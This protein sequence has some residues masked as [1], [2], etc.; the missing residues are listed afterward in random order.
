MAESEFQGFPP[1]TVR[2][3]VDLAA[4][5]D[6]DWFAANK[7]RYEED[8]VRPARAFITSVGSRLREFAPHVV[9]DPRVNGSLFR[10]SRDT[11]FSHD[12][13]PFKT[14]LGLWLWEGER[15]RMECSGFYLHVEPPNVLV[16]AGLYLFPAPLLHAWRS[17]LSHPKFG[18]ALAKAVAQVRASGPYTVHGEHYKRIPPGYGAP[19]ALSDWLRYNGLYAGL[20]M[21]AAG[22]LESPGFLESTVEHFRNLA[23]LHRWLLDMTRRTEG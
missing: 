18:P 16:A 20:E 2:F 15:A 10:I 6:R 19:P 22:T 12:K 9:A 13:T 8:V 4:H 23:P 14:H 3:L 7:A 17:S 11:R 5:N 21:P 1:G